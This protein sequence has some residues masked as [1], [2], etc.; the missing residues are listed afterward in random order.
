MRSIKSFLQQFLRAHLSTILRSPKTCNKKLK[1]SSWKG[2]TE[3]VLLTT[4]QE[5]N[6]ATKQHDPVVSEER[7]K[8]VCERV[9]QPYTRSKPPDLSAPSLCSIFDATACELW[10]VLIE[11]NTVFNNSTGALLQRAVSG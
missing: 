7:K 4:Q 8:K 6:L 1:Y 5:S 2:G 3:T 9:H 11:N 10:M